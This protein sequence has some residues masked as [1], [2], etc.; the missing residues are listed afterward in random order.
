MF[1]RFVGN[2]RRAVDLEDIHSGSCFL[3]GG[4]PILENKK[5]WEVLERSGAVTMA[6]NNVATLFKPTYWIGADKPEYYSKSIIYNSAYLHF[7]Y[8]SRCIC[9]IDGRQWKNYGNVIFLGSSESIKASNFFKPNAHFVWWRNVFLLAIQVLYH[10]GF[11]KI[12]TLGCS[13]NISKEQQYSFDTEL[14]NE[15]INYNITTYEM[16]MGQLKSIIPYF[17]K[18]DFQIISC[19]SNSRLNDIFEYISFENAGSEIIRK[20]PNHDAINIIHPVKKNT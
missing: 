3:V 5:Q 19:T 6:M 13:F 15:Q 8:L 4:S 7:A 10:L 16:V 2:E 14:T 9:E 18:N 20:I 17:E 1:Y 12:Y 11:R